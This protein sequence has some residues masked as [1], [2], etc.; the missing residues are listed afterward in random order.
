MSPGSSCK[1]FALNYFFL[2]I[3]KNY[4]QISKDYQKEDNDMKTHKDVVCERCEYFGFDDLFPY[5]DLGE[6]EKRF[7][8]FLDEATDMRIKLM[9]MR[10]KKD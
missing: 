4:L 7:K 10:N 9:S 8:D 5:D 3:K 2:I 1:Y 6:I